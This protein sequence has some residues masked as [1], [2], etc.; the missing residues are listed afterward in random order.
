MLLRQR[1]ICHFGKETFMRVQERGFEENIQASIWAEQFSKG[2]RLN[3]DRLADHVRSVLKRRLLSLGLS[4][5]D[6]EDLVQDCATLVFDAM[7]DYDPKRGSLDAWLSGYARNVA[8]SWW[9]GSY[10]RRQ[11]ESQLDTLTEICIDSAED[12]DRSGALEAALAE[13]NPIDQELL[14][15]RFL[16]GHSFDEIAHLANI[17]PINARKRV[18]RAV[19]TLRKNP[20]L[21]V[22]LGFDS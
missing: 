1:S 10:S 19:E 8:R 14:R 13:L 3:G 7:Q 6:T 17:T 9:R 12:I 20:P 22:E 16:F 5:Q 4:I 18:S 2:E 21:R 15:M 11:S